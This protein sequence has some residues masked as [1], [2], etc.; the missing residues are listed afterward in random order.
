MTKKKKFNNVDYQ[1]AILQRY[2]EGLLHYFARGGIQTLVLRIKSQ[3]L[4]HC[5]TTRLEN[6]ARVSLQ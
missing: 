6:N 3:L 2:L 1:L 5:A 4:Y